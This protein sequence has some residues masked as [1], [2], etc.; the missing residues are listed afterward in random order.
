MTA[1][2][3]W[4]RTLKSLIVWIIC[5]QLGTHAQCNSKTSKFNMNM[6]IYALPSSSSDVQTQFQAHGVSSIPDAC[7]FVFSDVSWSFGIPYKF[8]SVIDLNTT[9]GNLITIQEVETAF[10]LTKISVYN[11]KDVVISD[12]KECENENVCG[13]NTKCEEIEGSYQ[14]SCSDG[15]FSATH[16]SE[17]YGNITCEQECSSKQTVYEYEVE[18]KSSSYDEYNSSLESELRKAFSSICVVQF[19]NQVFDEKHG[20]KYK[21]NGVVGMNTTDGAI[22]S[23]DSVKTVFEM[24]LGSIEILKVKLEG[25]DEC[26]ENTHACEEFTVCKDNAESYT[27]VC[28]D[29]Y[30]VS[31]RNDNKETIACAPGLPT[32]TEETTSYTTVEATTIVLYTGS[33]TASVQYEEI[34]VADLSM[35]LEEKFEASLSV[36]TTSEF[37][38]LE[39]TLTYEVGKSLQIDRNFIGSTVDRFSEGSIVCHLEATFGTVKRSNPD[40][41]KRDLRRETVSSLEAF[42]YHFESVGLIGRYKIIPGSLFYVIRED[43][44]CYGQQYPCLDVEGVRVIGCIPQSWTCDKLADCPNADDEFNCTDVKNN[45]K[46]S[47]SGVMSTCGSEI[48]LSKNESVTISHSTWPKYYS[49]NSDCIWNISTNSSYWLSLWFHS[50]SLELGYVCEHDSLELAVPVNKL[51]SNSSAKYCG[52][53]SGISAPPFHSIIPQDEV[54]MRFKTDGFT[55]YCGFLLTVRPRIKY[56]GSGNKTC[57]EYHCQM[58][59]ISMCI[60]YSWVCDG[61]EDCFLGEDE[62]SCDYQNTFAPSCHKESSVKAPTQCVIESHCDRSDSQYICLPWS[63]CYDNYTTSNCFGDSSNTRSFESHSLSTYGFDCGNNISIP[64]SW[65]CDRMVD[66]P[67]GKDELN[68]SSLTKDPFDEIIESENMVKRCGGHFIGDN[69]TVFTHQN[70]P[71]KYSSSTSCIW[72]IQAS[73]GRVVRIFFIKFALPSVAGCLADML[74]VYDGPDASHPLI[75]WHCRT[76]SHIPLYITSTNNTM[77]IIFK[78]DCDNNGQLVLAYKGI[79]PPHMHELMKS[80]QEDCYITGFSYR[81]NASTTGSGLECQQ[82]QKQSPWQHDQLPEKLP[83]AGLDENYCRYP[84][85]DWRKPFQAPRCFTLNDSVPFESCDQIPRCKFP[86]CPYDDMYQCVTGD[87]IP[88]TRRCDDIPDCPLMDDENDCQ[89]RWKDFQQIKHLPQACA[90]GVMPSSQANI[91]SQNGYFGL[92]DAFDIEYENTTIFCEWNIELSSAY[93]LLLFDAYNLTNPNDYLQIWEHNK[94]I[95]DSRITSLP[96]SSFDMMVHSNSLR[97]ILRA[98]VSKASPPIFHMNYKEEICVYRVILPSSCKHSNITEGEITSPGYPYSDY[99]PGTTCFWIFTQEKDETCQSPEN[100]FRIEFEVIEIKIESVP[101]KSSI[102]TTHEC[103][104]K[105]VFYNGIGPNKQPIRSPVCGTRPPSFK[106]L[107]SGPDVIVKFISDR[108][109]PLAIYDYSEGYADV[110]RKPNSCCSYDCE[111]NYACVDCPEDTGYFSVLYRFVQLDSTESTTSSDSDTSAPKPFCVDSWTEWFNVAKPSGITIAGVTLSGGDF[112]SIYK[113][114]Q[115]YDE[116]WGGNGKLCSESKTVAIECRTSNGIPWQQTGQIGLECDL[117]DGFM[118]YNRPQPGKCFDYEVRFYCICNESSSF[119]MEEI[120]PFT[121][122]YNTFTQQNDVA[123]DMESSGSGDIIINTIHSNVSTK[124]ELTTSFSNGTQ[125]TSTMANDNE[126]MITEFTKLKYHTEAST[127]SE[128]KNHEEIITEFPSSKYHTEASTKSELKN[129]EEMITEFPSSK[130]HTEASTKSE[131]KNHEEAITEFPSSKYHSEASTKSETKNHEEMITEFPSSK[132]HSEASTKSESK[133]HE[134]M[135]T[136]FPSSEYHT[137]ASTKSESKTQL[138]SKHSISGDEG[139][140]TSVRLVCNPG[141][142]SWLQIQ[143]STDINFS[144][145]AEQISLLKDLTALLQSQDICQNPIAV[146]CRRT[147]DKK[148]I[149]EIHKE[150][151]QGGS[152]HNFDPEYIC[153]PQ[154]GVKCNQVVPCHPCDSME[155]KLYCG[156][157]GD[158]NTTVNVTPYIPPSQPPEKIDPLLCYHCKDTKTGKCSDALTMDMSVGN[159]TNGACWSAVYYDHN[160]ITEVWRGCD[161]SRCSTAYQEEKCFYTGSGRTKAVCTTC[162]ENELCNMHSFENTLNLIENG[163]FHFNQSPLNFVAHLLTYY[164]FLI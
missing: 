80:F 21:A 60:P 101:S 160:G 86:K 33:T 20:G 31:K 126:Y 112:E 114:R 15:N 147:S 141:W 2:E 129:H 39:S 71:E 97:V 142:T 12:Y 5:T 102:V 155:F 121:A 103:I 119:N 51:S 91:T 28:V 134:E 144:T 17:L 53:L 118:C 89:Y 48:V 140:Q 146:S 162:C 50:F 148:S 113:I 105:L 26:E 14:C 72:T 92:P 115:K 136:E 1:C 37:Q 77:T 133:N 132:Y 65:E 85:E 117:F 56:L 79:P 130:Y 151:K 38:S 88:V 131:S 135:I 123:T 27:C 154:L 44:S 54:Y 83:N 90:R 84:L 152:S 125:R 106:I 25:F 98:T 116:E 75:G 150:I 127:K 164:L 122:A 61:E 68:C 19:W 55:N 163:A 3:M 70:F 16:T 93:L 156:C 46:H 35:A 58:S 145:F 67:S 138:R 159:C 13:Q 47:N 100:M 6:G 45:N 143:S 109:N 110:R 23:R 63:Q 107:S 104:D 94:V 82:W 52:I 64:L 161:S 36:S 30:V 137:E 99:N 157:P 111:L 22:L 95:L 32:L 34:L 139:E 59:S 153:D 120:I 74:T 108:K 40:D 149:F 4:E 87:C 96:S 7:S 10:S 24:D 18:M 43:L 11:F 8:S 66:C 124:L 128:S 29:N 41:A 81:G 78:S 42:I 158:S 9:D 49:P 69:L 62:E 76:P 57:R 73:I